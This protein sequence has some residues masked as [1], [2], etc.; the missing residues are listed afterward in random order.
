MR[1]KGGKKKEKK[2]CVL[3]TVLLACLLIM[4]P[5]KLF[6]VKSTA[7]ELRYWERVGN[8]FKIC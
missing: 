5:K 3:F 7:G 1:K 4:G 8:Q 6:R 2:V